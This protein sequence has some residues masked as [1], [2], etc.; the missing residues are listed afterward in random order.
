MSCPWVTKWSEALWNIIALIPALGRQRQA[1]LCELETGLISTP[2]TKNHLTQL[3]CLPQPR[4]PLP[5]FFLFF[6]LV[7]YLFLKKKDLFI[8]MH[9]STL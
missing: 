5:F 7:L 3:G 6:S 1:E 9:M 4:G 2:P 8:F